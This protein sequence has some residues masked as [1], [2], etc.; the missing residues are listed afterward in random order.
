MKVDVEKTH[1]MNLEQ[2]VPDQLNE[3]LAQVNSLEDS[4]KVI[5]K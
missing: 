2:P 4:I 3:K 5:I 1:Y